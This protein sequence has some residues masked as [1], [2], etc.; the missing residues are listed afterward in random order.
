MRPASIRRHGL[1][2]T[3]G[4]RRVARGDARRRLALLLPLARRLAV[5]LT[6]LSLA[7]GACVGLGLGYQALRQSPRFGLHQLALSGNRQLDSEE[8]LSYAGLRL[9]EPLIGIDP[10]LTAARLA[11]H[12]WIREASVRRVL[13]DTLA[14]EI[15][16]RRPRA[17]V[18]L[19]H[20]YLADE[21]G[22][23]FLRVRP[24]GLTGPL[25]ELPL[26]TGLTRARFELDPQAARRQVLGAVRLARQL[27]AGPL[28]QGRDG[29]R[30][31]E[32][33]VDLYT[34]YEV[35]LTPG[36]L[37]LTLGWEQHDER[38]RDAGAV[39]ATLG[40]RAA[41]ARALYLDN[42]RRPERAVVRLASAAEVATPTEQPPRAPRR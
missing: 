28:T 41:Q 19:E 31:S 32:V 29:R 2:R 16:E 14:V 30:V 37:R 22:E 26:V 40:G 38:L 36:P 33:H 24:A 23:P 20:L 18:A 12:A 7:A 13:P 1:L 9:G 42:A 5:G 17:V 10:S 15:S 21:D 25:A 34:G 8:V 4:N 39:L 3:T 27:A 11:K 6:A 35:V